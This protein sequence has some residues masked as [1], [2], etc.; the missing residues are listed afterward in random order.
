VL[1]A[2]RIGDIDYSGSAVLAEVR[3]EL[4]ERGIALE[5][6]RLQDRPRMQL[7]RDIGHADVLLTFSTEPQAEQGR[8]TLGADGAVELYLSHAQTSA[9]T[10]SDAVGQM[11]V[12]FANGDVERHFEIALCVDPE[13]T[14]GD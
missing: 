9:I 10:W 7:R 5:L 2:D 12:T 1:E 13:G 3:A 14:R 6:C 11:E 4:A 8:I